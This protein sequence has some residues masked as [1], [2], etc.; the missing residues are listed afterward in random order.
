MQ[1]RKHLFGEYVERG[2]YHRYLDPNWSYYPYYIA[3]MN[4]VLSYIKNNVNQ[5]SKILDVGCGD[6]VLVEK[7]RK[8]GYKNTFGID[9]NF[10]SKDVILGNI[11]NLPFK[12][13]SFDIV[14]CLDVLE[15]LTFMEQKKALLEI[16][17][18]VK[19]QKMAIFSIPNLAHLKSRIL[20]LLKGELNRTSR[21]ERHPGDRPIKEFIN[22]IEKTG[23]EIIERK[24]FLFFS[25]LK[26]LNPIIHH[27]PDLCLMNIF[28][29]KST[30][31]P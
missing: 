26:F 17:R 11:L 29:C 28:I 27:F 4:Y 2:E 23:F 31:T 6:G 16:Q 20:F 3:K 25:K 12:N 24:G 15:H 18:V 1:D 8:D 19:K 14:L 10:A 7:L 21:I 9:S 13:K 30:S 22:L 5:N